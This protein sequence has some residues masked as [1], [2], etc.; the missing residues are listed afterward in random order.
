VTSS[1]HMHVK[2]MDPRMDRSIRGGACR[3]CMLL[4]DFGPPAYFE[5]FWSRFLVFKTYTT[6]VISPANASKTAMTTPA[7]AMLLAF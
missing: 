6:A 5:Y 1:G 2:G 7:M 4:T 3:R